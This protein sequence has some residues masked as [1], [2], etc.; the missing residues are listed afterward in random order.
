MTPRSPDS[1]AALD[2]ALLAAHEIGDPAALAGLYGRAAD[3]AHAAGNID[4]GCFFD[5]QAMVFALVAGIGGADRHHARLK[6][7]GRER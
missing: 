7:H 2:A 6:R 4:A 1:D 5:T 3:R